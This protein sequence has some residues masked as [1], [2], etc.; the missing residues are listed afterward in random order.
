MI[1]LL[2]DYRE[3]KILEYFKNN[4]N[5]E[6]IE[7]RNLLVGDIIF[8]YNDE[9]ILIIE[10]KTICDLISSITD[11]RYK[12]QKFRL[13]KNNNENNLL[14][15]LE[16]EIEEPKYGY[17]KKKNILGSIIN[18]MFRDKINIYKTFDIEETCYFIECILNK[19]IKKEKK[20]FTKLF[21]TDNIEENIDNNKNKSYCETIKLSKKSN[22]TPKIFNELI[23]LQ[24]PGVSKMFINGIFSKY[25]SIKELILIYNDDKLNEKEKNNLLKD[26]KIKTENNKERKIGP[27]ISKRIYEFLNF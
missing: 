4:K 15:L 23:L 5:K 3:K 2:I 18:T 8:T 16:G 24:I 7:K 10:R 14:I 19:L 17:M 1:K 20:N 6:Y 12:E 26:I 13:L 11:G 25:K 21:N 9:K 22:L 27:V